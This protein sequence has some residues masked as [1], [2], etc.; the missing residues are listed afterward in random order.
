MAEPVKSNQQH[1]FIHDAIC[2]GPIE[3]LV[4]GDSSIFF[5]GQRVQDL[6]PD[7]PWTPVN[8]K[9]DFSTSSDTTG[10]NIVPAL[11]ISF[12]ENN[13]IPKNDTFLLIRNEGISKSSAT[14]DYSTRALTITGA[15]NFSEIY[16]TFNQTATAANQINV[17]SGPLPQ[18]TI[19]NGKITNG[20][21]GYIT[22]PSVKVFK[23]ISA[24]QKT[25]VSTLS[26]TVS[27][28][29]GSVT[30]INFTSGNSN[31]VG[32]FEFEISSPP[33]IEDRFIVLADPVTNDIMYVGEGQWTSGTT[34]KFIP[35][36][37]DNYTPWNN[38]LT[39]SSYKVQVL[40]SIKISS[41]NVASN[42]ITIQ[43]GPSA[44]G[45]TYCFT[46]S[47]SKPGSADDVDVDDPPQSNNFVAQFRGGYTYQDPITELNGVGGG[48]SYTADI[49]SLKTPLL[50]QINYTSWND[51]NPDDELTGTLVHPTGDYPEGQTINTEGALEPVE[52]N[53]SLFG[54]LDSVVPTLDEVRISIQYG[55]F[56]AIR[57]DNADEVHNHAKYLFQIARK[58]PG[59]N[60]FEKYKAVFKTPEGAGK[61]TIE[62]RG[63]DKSAVSFEHYIDLSIIKPFVDFK[64]RIFRLTRHKGRAVGSGGG[65]Q[66]PAHDTDQGDATAQI[67]NLVAINKDKFSYPYTAHAGLFLDSREYSGIPKRSY[68]VRGMKIKVPQGYKPREYSG[69]VQAKTNDAGTT[70]NYSVPTYPEFW[71]GSLTDELY[72]TNNPVW[73]FLDIITNDRFGAGEWVKISDI[74]IYSLY[75]VSKYCD[76]LVPDGKGG[77]EPRF[78]ANLY[79]S[80]ATDVYKVV[81]DMATVFTSLVY[82]MDGQLTTIMDAPGDPVYS[83][84]RAN[85][86]DGEFTYESTGQKTRT[87]QVVVTWNNPEIG[88]EKVP[89]I[90][91]DRDDIVSSGR[92]VKENAVA[93]GVTSEGQARRY[94]KWKLFTAQGQTE[95]VSFKTSF[96]GLFLKPGDIIEVQDAARYGKS[97]SGRVSSAT[98]TSGKHV[99]TL[100]REVTL[101]TTLFNYK[102]AVL[103]TKPAAYYVGEDALTVDHETGN[104]NDNQTLTR[105]D[106]ILKAWVRDAASGN[107]TLG[108]I[109]SE[110]KAAHAFT[111]STG[112]QLIELNWKKDSFVETV[113]VDSSAVVSGKTEITVDGTFETIPEASSI[114]MLEETAKVGGLPSTSSPDLYKILGIAQSDKNIY[115]ISAVEHLNSKYAFVD[116]PDAILD[117]PDDVYA[118]E[119]AIVPAPA[120]VFILQNSNAARPNEEI[121]IE[122][123]YPEF[124]A[125]GK[126][127]S[128]FLDSFE[129]LHTVPDR[130]NTFNLGKNARR[131]S[132]RNVPDG[133]YMF[134]VRAI[135]VSQHKSAW[136]SSRYV[137]E[138]PFD[139]SVNRNKGI[140]TEGL[141]SSI[142]FVTNESAAQGNFRG[143]FDSTIGAFHSS[144]NT[145]GYKVG[146]FVLD[147]S[148]VY[149]YLPSSG[150]ATNISTWLP[151]RGGIFK[152]REDTNPVIAPSRFRREEALTF[153]PNFTLDV[154]ILRSLTWP[155]VTTG[156]G[157]Y[158]E[159]VLDHSTASDNSAST[160]AL[161][162]LHAKYDGDLGIF[163]WYDVKDFMDSSNTGLAKYWNNSGATVS[164]TAGTNKITR[165]SGSY[166]FNTLNN[167][168]KIVFA[169]ELE[170]STISFVSG[171]KTISNLN[172]STVS[173]LEIGSAIEISGVQADNTGRF[174]VASK[175]S[176]TSITVEEAIVT[177][178]PNVTIH[179]V[180]SA[181]RVAYVKN[182]TELFLD[183]KVTKTFTASD[184][185][186]LWTQNYAPDFRKDVIIGR[187]ANRTDTDNNTDT[188][189]FRFQSFLTVDPSLQ[190]DRSLLLDLNESFLQYNPDQELTL[191]P[192]KL[193]L[194][195]TA[196]GFD[197][198][199]F[200]ID[201][202]DTEPSGSPMPL[203]AEDTDF[204]DPTSGLFTY[205]VD[206]W[207]GANTIPFDGGASIQ[208]RV[209]VVEKEDQ[210]D[211]DKT[212]T[213]TIT[214]AKVGDVAAGEGSR[215]VFL[216]L[217]DYD[218][219]YD[220]NGAN[221]SF[222]P[223]AAGS[224]KIRLTATAS[225]GFGDP[226][227]RFKVGGAVVRADNY[228]DADWFDPG[229]DIASVNWPVPTTL[230]ANGAFTWVNENG[231]SKSVVV[232]VAEK[233]SNWTATVPESGT[234]TNEPPTDKIFAKDVD[235]ILGLRAG[236]DGISIN[237]INDSH[238]V[239]CDND[240]NVISNSDDTI[241]NSGA[242]IKVFKGAAKLQYI[243]SGDPN[244]SQFTIPTAGITSTEALSGGTGIVPGTPTTTTPSGEVAHALIPDH[245]F[246]GKIGAPFENTE[247]IT[248]PI[249]VGMPGGETDV[250]MSVTQTFALVKDGTRGTTVG[251]VFLYKRSVNQP[252]Q[253]STN[254]KNVKVNLATGLIAFD[255]NDDTIFANGE[256]GWYS[257]ANAAFAASGTSGQL[258]IVAA[259][260]N[261]T[262]AFDDIANTEWTTAVQFT[263]ADGLNSATVELFQANNTENQAPELPGDLTYTFN[264][265]GL[266]APS[267]SLGLRGWSQTMPAPISSAEYVW[268]TSAAAVSTEDTATIDGVDA[269]PNA[270]GQD[271]SAPVIVARYVEASLFSISPEHQLF[272]IQK[273]GTIQ[274][275][276][277]KITAKKT[278][279]TGTVNW[280]GATFYTA[281]TD[282]STTTT[283]D[284]VY[285]RAS[286]LA[287][288]AASVTITGS[289]SYQGTTFTDTESIEVVE[290]GATGASA[291]TVSLSNDNVVLTAASNGAVTDFSG[292][293][294]TV[295]VKEGATDLTPVLENATLGNG[296][297]Q[298]SVLESG[299]GFAADTSYTDSDITN[300]TESKSVSFGVA[301]AI[302]NSTDTATRT[303]NITGKTG[304]GTNFTASKVQGFS[305][306]KQGTQGTGTQGDPGQ[307]TVTGVVYYQTA[308]TD[309]NV[310][311]VPQLT[312]FSADFD[313]G[314]FSYENGWG[315]VPP[316]AT[317]GSQTSY[318]YFHLTISESGNYTNNAWDDVDKTASPSV[319]S[320]CIK[321]IGFTGLV[322]FNSDGYPSAIGG[323]TYNPFN[324]LNATGSTDATGNNTTTTTINGN[325]IRSGTIVADR[326][327][328]TPVQTIGSESPDPN[329]VISSTNLRTALNLGTL[330]NQSTIDL[331]NDLA[332]GTV[333][334]KANGG[335][336][337]STGPFGYADSSLFISGAGISLLTDVYANANKTGVNAN[338]ALQ[339]TAARLY[340][341][342]TIASGSDAGLSVDSTTKELSLTASQLSLQSSQVGLG[343]VSNLAPA[344]QVGTGF[345][346]TITAGQMVLQSSTD[347]TS[348]TSNRIELDA[349]TN[350]IRVKD[351]GVVRVILGKLT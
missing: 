3:G 246:K 309:S 189:I 147:S 49:G 252:N 257:T 125:S 93:F 223:S 119:P 181:G 95:I 74:D 139:D 8:A 36:F 137:V 15:S 244:S 170:T 42:Q 79:L 91:E 243:T 240:G 169:K 9:I 63:K 248:Y 343:L 325:V 34:L 81:K 207:D 142:P 314:T 284:V 226:I 229:G 292:S 143:V 154:N 288:D 175:P 273:N 196:F 171:T 280:S 18:L 130:E 107:R 163:Y 155:G 255:S 151:Y 52:I 134:R 234:N 104:S 80:K 220:T 289:I 217:S 30:S 164:F 161:R 160:P 37:Q 46:I 333:L 56:Q 285:I 78:T 230:H 85:V 72:Y 1:I 263:G 115:S 274:P 209:V 22:A 82:W 228:S 17:S 266:S 262:G 185:I 41:F 348:S 152:F 135:S 47:G 338:F 320:D 224:G 94:G 322:T 27:I 87:N 117:I 108:V 238:V 183:R 177:E 73:I 213:E 144:S 331:A 291:I 29:E 349:G 89:L 121:T 195:A 146:D 249:T 253:P 158:A 242:Q 346:T 172:T 334:D 296:Q 165:A 300:T 59:S 71:N 282:G 341:S 129:I 299:S 276:A 6:D 44:G 16:R 112:G 51:A 162:L 215:S 39:T 149:Y 304:D 188:G 318:Y 241:S 55:Q 66:P 10:S 290:D 116:D 187:V 67:S 335:T 133:T 205:K 58:A 150:T 275:S 13:G 200:K 328:F 247:A 167:L 330:A 199:L 340:M 148:N 12:T 315:A 306:A 2:E 212:V 54:S 283:G 294:C 23:V 126:P 264:P 32:T 128:R 259:T 103:I 70:A 267:G 83:F 211:T 201:Y 166:D 106:R 153:T 329:G 269:D 180:I 210:G 302:G 272:V 303:F 321:G 337:S 57:K 307:R 317:P 221:P 20:G 98:T 140:Q 5:N 305:K 122:W 308:V 168:N 64:I 295:K 100:D 7:A 332:S 208:I 279:I 123:E 50:K 157:R 25:L 14:Y 33:L 258:W 114:W 271:W 297:Y 323:S 197:D 136:T 192:N 313:D 11:P 31:L 194:T 118:P 61:P 287:A 159:L 293:Q 268:R 109:D 339:L 92:I 190:G 254:F 222:T 111:A 319:G 88:Y 90:V 286:D 124:D 250:S 237:F 301:T 76:E 40:E 235:N 174:H 141:A 336:G 204:Q 105:G 206:I 97:L 21:S 131:F 127:T 113:A 86:I 260:A 345:N 75:R 233:P 344:G 198:P 316:T 110:V 96:E 277:I 43:N 84:S 265:P 245:V 53:A 138:D 202:N 256:E 261:G 77:F 4:Y 176:T 281:E 35:T 311:E 312:N 342:A 45:G 227:F 178:N 278:N 69:A 145:G 232:E 184:S 62:H 218:V 156:N 351:G 347:G 102:I 216:E 231:G 326:L 251:Q 28:S 120:N 219:L 270:D 101:D 99:V 48:V 193:T 60:S 186:Q 68:E 203:R 191:A 173:A 324:H 236:H 310:P 225:P 65:D 19:A 26:A 182:N 239:P 214:L 298:I 38:K 179:L 132:L 327:S 24:T 350:Q